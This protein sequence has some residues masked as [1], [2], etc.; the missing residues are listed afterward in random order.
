MKRLL[1]PVLGCAAALSMTA[2]STVPP[3]TQTEPDQWQNQPWNLVAI[4]GKT[5]QSSATLEVNDESQA[6][7]D[8]GCNRFFGFSSM[9]DTQFRVEKMG[10]TRMACLDSNRM[11][12]EQIVTDVLT[13]WSEVS[14]QNGQLILASDEHTLTYQTSIKS[15]IK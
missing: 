8:T 11:Q 10:M 7:G 5:V 12:V 2:C 3:T 1:L 4:D 13:N 15:G 6:I 14:M 9:Q